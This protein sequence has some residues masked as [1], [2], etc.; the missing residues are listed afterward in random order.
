MGQMEVRST[1]GQSGR[2]WNRQ[3]PFTSW[4]PGGVVEGLRESLFS[5]TRSASR[6]FMLR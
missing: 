1:S 2:I 4:A 3:V 5:R 6:M